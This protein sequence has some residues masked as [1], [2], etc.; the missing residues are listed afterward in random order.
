M[1]VF[2]KL[3]VD[4]PAGSALS[5]ITPAFLLTHPHPAIPGSLHAST[6]AV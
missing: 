5:G 6:V 4:F 1:L 3:A 2:L